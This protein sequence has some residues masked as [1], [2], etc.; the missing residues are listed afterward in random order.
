[1]TAP[2]TI[3]SQDLSERLEFGCAATGSRRP[4]PWRVRDRPHRRRLQRSA[5]PAARAPRRD[6]QASRRRG[7]AG[8]PL[9]SAGRAGRGDPARGRPGQR[10]HPRWRDH[11][12][13]GE[14][15]RGQ[16]RRTAL[17][18]RAP[19]APGRRL[20]R[21]DQHPGQHRRPQ[22]QVGRR[23]DRRRTDL[24]GADQ[25]LRHGHGCCPSCPT[26]AAPPAT[27]RPSYPSSSVPPPTRRRAD[28]HDRTR[29]SPWPYSSASRWACSAAAD[30]S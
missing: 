23:R 18:P 12:L 4:N 11:R 8:L 15:F 16:P 20:D 13:G 26:T 25:H 14:G 27:P 2:T 1:M 10:A 3:D 29:P 30:R 9:R 6:H 19:G 22:A 17:G 28:R 21:A 24:R 5:G 7:R